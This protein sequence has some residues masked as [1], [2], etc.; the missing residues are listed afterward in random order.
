M[1]FKL[2]PFSIPRNFHLKKLECPLSPGERP[3][4]LP[5][6]RLKPRNGSETLRVLDFRDQILFRT[7]KY[8]YEDRKLD[9]CASLEVQR[10]LVRLAAQCGSQIASNS[11][12]VDQF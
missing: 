6:A 3:Q 9:L 5:I 11:A 7:D 2:D 8:F 10:N 4:I 12:G 1:V